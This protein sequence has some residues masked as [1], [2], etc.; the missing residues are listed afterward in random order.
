MALKTPLISPYSEMT[1]N[2]CRYLSIFTAIAAP[3]STAATTIASIVF[4]IFWLISGQAISSVKH[5][6]QQPFGKILVLFS[7]WLVIGMFYAETDWATRL[8][9]LSSWK[10]LL[11][12][13]LLLGIFHHRDWQKRFISL[14]AI[15]MSLAASIALISWLFEI[16]IRPSNGGGPGIIMTNYVTQSMAFIAAILCS[17]FLLKEARNNLNKYFLLG[18]IILF[19]F[20]VFFISQARSAYLSVAVSIIFAIGSIYGLR[21]VPHISATVALA[22][23]IFGLSSN[24]LQER[25]KLAM[26]E[27]ANYQIS[28]E[29]TS[30]GIRVVFYKNTLELIK[31]NPWLGYGTSSF[32]SAYNPLAASKNQDWRGSGT[33]D[34]HNQYLF[35]W[36]ENGLV[37]LLLFVA[38]IAIGIRQGIHNQPYGAVGASFLVAIATSSLFNSHFKTF[39]EGYLLAFFLGSLLPPSQLRSQTPSHE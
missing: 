9:T 30:V 3:I 34:P 36:A 2:I 5:A 31:Q 12:V 17:I 35:V 11:F 23:I 25:V 13:F 28:N 26:E 10:K 15:A 32:E 7:L 19:L 20:N 22:L 4:L 8:T 21:K 6:W 38:Y 1:L 39:P 18:I 29:L 14:Y 16:N 27:G 24:T 33:T 37:G